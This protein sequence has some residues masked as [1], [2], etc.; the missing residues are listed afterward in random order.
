VRGFPFLELGL[1]LDFDS[2]VMAEVEKKFLI[3]VSTPEQQEAAS[4]P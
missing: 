1:E 2:L 3:A 4:L